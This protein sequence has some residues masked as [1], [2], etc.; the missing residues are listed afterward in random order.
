MPE[1]LRLLALAGKPAGAIDRWPDLDEAFPITVLPA[2]PQ[3]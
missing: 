1:C 2:A 3:S